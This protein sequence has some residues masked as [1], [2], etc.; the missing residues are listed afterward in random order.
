MPTMR[1]R[2]F[3]RLAAWGCAA[4]GVAAVLGP[5]PVQAQAAATTPPGR[6]W[7]SFAYFPPLRQLVLFGG[8][9]GSTV[10]GD[11]WTRTGSTWTQQHPATSPS[12]RTGA[13]SATRCRASPT[14]RRRRA[15]PR[16][17]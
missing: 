15:R 16:A 1:R 14:S 6:A 2:I 9:K 5:A 10:Y 8:N 12:P 4:L 7:A 17:S 3:H 11:T 13:S